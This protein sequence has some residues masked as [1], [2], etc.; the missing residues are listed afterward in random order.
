MANK[1]VTSRKIIS[2]P[3]PLDLWF[4]D[5]KKVEELR[6]ILGSEALQTAIAI[7]KEISGP[8]NGGIGSDPVTTSQRYAWSAGYRDAFN[9]LY[10]LTK[11]RTENKTQVQEEWKHIQIQQQ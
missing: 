8:T 5:V 2:L 3:V 6:E 4:K 7:L 10:K 11:Y 9:D 1:K